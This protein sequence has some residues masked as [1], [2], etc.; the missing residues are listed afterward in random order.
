[1]GISD[2]Q[3]TQIY[4]EPSSDSHKKSF[5]ITILGRTVDSRGAQ[6]R[7]L[8]SKKTKNRLLCKSVGTE[9]RKGNDKQTG[10]LVPPGLKIVLKGV[11]AF[12]TKVSNHSERVFHSADFL[13]YLGNFQWCD[14]TFREKHLGDPVC[15]S[16]FHKK[17][18]P[19]LP[20]N[21]WGFMLLAYST[22]TDCLP[23][24]S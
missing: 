2:P 10:C 18:P 9:Q 23:S 5:A 22:S 12:E 14:W 6:G 17:F 3:W 11:S 13:F 24:A 16:L 1:M 19:F 21:K 8:S 7:N 15:F 4:V 20:K